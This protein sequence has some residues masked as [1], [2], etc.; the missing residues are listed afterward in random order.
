MGEGT[1]E[2]R[3]PFEPP[4]DRG[5]EEADFPESPTSLPAAALAA[6][7]SPRLYDARQADRE[8]WQIA[9]PSMLSMV[10][11]SLV[12]L[13]DIAMIG[14]LGTE[15]L[16]AVGY[17]SQYLWLAQSV[18]FAIGIACVALMARAI[19]A[20]DP[21]RAR[22]AL[23]A[24]IV[25]S[26]C[27]AIVVCGLVIAIPVPLLAALD[28]PEE[29][30]DLTV[31]YMRLTL[32]SAVLFAVAIVIESGFRAAKDTRTPMWIA[33]IITII[34]TGLNVLLIFG[35]LGF[36]RLELV[37]AG[38]ATVISQAVAVVLFVY[39]SRVHRSREVLRFQRR[40]VSRAAGLVGEVIRIALPA[41]AE[42]VILNVAILTYF[43]LLGRYGAGAIAAYTVGVRILAFS[44]IPGIGF[45]TAA[46][47]L[48]GQALGARDPWGASRAGWRAARFA[49]V[50][51]AVLGGLYALSRNPLARLF[52]DDPNVVQELGPFMLILALSQPFMGVHFTLGGALR[53]AGDT[54][55]P[56]W[57][58]ALGNWGFRVPLAF[59]ASRLLDLDVIW[60][61]LALMLDHAARAVWMTWA[62]RAGRWARSGP[63]D[64]RA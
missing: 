45:S 11:A 8:I 24:S 54:V 20:G 38:I 19:G 36:P 51:S 25:L 32:G 21:A 39:A 17:A 15:A 23:G 60:L 48:V 1:R 5:L 49:L 13:I 33:G 52:T 57:A 64:L 6:H 42:R 14:R 10:M 44:W 58:A 30:I 31:P 62:F 40:D 35:V 63:E 55:T 46:S 41:I 61:W 34:K 28:A 27:A 47:T 2:K 16:A 37:G 7:A 4:V 59:A 12:S 50:V 18:L 3:L 53:G 9:W 22:S 56:L 43:G 29:V 26:V